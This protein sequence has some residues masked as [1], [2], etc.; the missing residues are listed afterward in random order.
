VI[1]GARGIGAKVL[2][3]IQERPEYGLNAVGFLDGDPSLASSKEFGGE[4][5]G[6]VDDL[7]VVIR[8][9]EIEHVIL[10]FPAMPDH[11][12]VALGKQCL[13]LGLQVSIIPRGFEFTNN[14]VEL[15][16]LGK[17]PLVAFYFVDPKGWQFGIKHV[18][19]RLVTAFALLILALP[20][21]I[22][23]GLIMLDRSS[24]SVIFRQKRVGRDGQV[25]DLFKF[26]TMYDDIS[27]SDFQPQQ[28]Y[29]PGGIEGE[30][31]R[32]KMGCWLRRW[33]L[34]ELPQ[35]INV[36]RGEMS[37][38]GPRPERPEFVSQ[39]DHDIEHY[40]QRHRVKSGITGW[41]QVNCAR[42]NGLLTER[43]EWDNY[44][45]ENWSLWLDFKILLMTMVAVGR[46]AE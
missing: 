16:R 44:Y 13:Q 46:G 23:A 2:K 29:A 35:L 36:L 28:G 31:R 17:L 7:F 11:K 8:E 40:S 21:A 20:M 32:T 41:A 4:V 15:D 5:L 30:D 19:D 38:I 3:R 6:D 14:R 33:S 22:I 43:I 25:F 34:D 18:L 45:I 42:R 39:F 12:L 10:A 37:L 27:Q 24:S 9:H 26:R 1:I